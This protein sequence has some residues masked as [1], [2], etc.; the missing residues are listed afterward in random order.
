MSDFERALEKE[1]ARLKERLEH[2]LGMSSAPAR[3]RRGPS[4]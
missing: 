2:L 1:I 3:A 4:Q